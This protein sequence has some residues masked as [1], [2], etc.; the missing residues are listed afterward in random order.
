[1]TIQYTNPNTQLIGFITSKFNYIASNLQNI[2]TLKNILNTHMNANIDRLR[3]NEDITIE[4][5]NKKLNIII[6]S[7]LIFSYIS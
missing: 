1:M 5:K 7:D 3:G 2:S 4:F 6:Q